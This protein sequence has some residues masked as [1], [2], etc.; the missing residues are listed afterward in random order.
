MTVSYATS[1]Q[2]HE[3]IVGNVVV[4]DADRLLERASELIDSVIRAP[5]ALDDD[6]LPADAD[7]A[8]SLANAACAQVE[9][10]LEVG[11]END[12]DG[13]AGDQIAVTGFSGHRAPALAPRAFRFLQAAGLLNVSL[14]GVGAGFFDCGCP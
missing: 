7:V 12:I 5:F 11:E 14:A 2:L 4:S 1:R 13:L 6:G 3:F 8:T 10:W 9:Q